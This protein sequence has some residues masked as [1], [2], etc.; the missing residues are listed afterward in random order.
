MNKKKILIIAVIVLAVSI[1]TV[2]TLLFVKT[3]NANIVTCSSSHENDGVKIEQKY[4]IKYEKDKVKNV[5]ITKIYEF[6]E[7]KRFDT[8]SSVVI[9]NT[10]SSM[11]KLTN[12]DIK[13]TS[14]VSGKTYTTNTV[15]TAQNIKDSVIDDLGVSKSLKTLKADLQSQGLICK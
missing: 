2:G 13:Y 4:V 1:L 9:P 10:D 14:N 15:V 6:S 8:F 12:S 11:K 5:N 7:Q 3:V